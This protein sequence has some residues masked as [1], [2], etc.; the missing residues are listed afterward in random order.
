MLVTGTMYSPFLLII[1]HF[2]I[3]MRD[4]CFSIFILLALFCRPCTSSRLLFP[5]LV[6]TL[7]LIVAI[8]FVA[9]RG[10][11]S[12]CDIFRRIKFAAAFRRLTPQLETIERSCEESFLPEGSGLMVQHS[13]FLLRALVFVVVFLVVV[14]AVMVVVVVAA[15]GVVVVKAVDVVSISLIT[16]LLQHYCRQSPGIDIPKMAARARIVSTNSDYRSQP[17]EF[18]PWPTFKP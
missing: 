7:L 9:L 18:K 17:V 4:S 12:A 10:A 11:F 13:G 1:F 16:S 2:R 14:L 8:S 5:L 3:H 15:A 6:S